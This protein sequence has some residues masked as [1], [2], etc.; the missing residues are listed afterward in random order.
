[1]TD[2]SSPNCQWTG[3]SPDITCFS[4]TELGRMETCV[5]LT[6]QGDWEI[7]CYVLQ[8]ESNL[9]HWHGS[10]TVYQL[11]CSC[12]QTPTITFNIILDRYIKRYYV[13]KIILS[14]CIGGNAKT[15]GQP[16][17][18]VEEYSVCVTKDKK[19]VG[20]VEKVERSIKIEKLAKTCLTSQEW[21]SFHLFVQRSLEKGPNL[22]IEK[23]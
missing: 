17:E 10:T 19:S 15:E 8:G 11:Y 18:L 3:V 5:G 7:Y 21:I 16:G 14:L 9:S 12:L 4:F 20:H 2:G 13:Y 23:D 6:V 1:M 22:V